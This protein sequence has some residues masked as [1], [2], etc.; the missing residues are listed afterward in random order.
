MTAF[1]LVF[2]TRT[3]CFFVPRSGDGD[4]DGD[5]GSGVSDD[6][7]DAGG[8]GRGSSDLR[9]ESADNTQANPH[10]SPDMSGCAA[11]SRTTS[12]AAVG[13]D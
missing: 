8:G 4:G 7:E 11:A 2:G 1:R 13:V 6:E 9:D 12:M 5:G 3:D 10:S